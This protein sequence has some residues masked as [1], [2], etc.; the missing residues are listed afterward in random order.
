MC[1]TIVCD[2][3]FT[4]AVILT[5]DLVFECPEFCVPDTRKI[6]SFRCFGEYGADSTVYDL[7]RFP[8]PPLPKASKGDTLRQNGDKKATPC[9]R[10]GTTKGPPSKAI[11]ATISRGVLPR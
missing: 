4:S 7:S 8:F 3:S 9:A 6:Y 11:R 5:I 10:M 2:I 1:L